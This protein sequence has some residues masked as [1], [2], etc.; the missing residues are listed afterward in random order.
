MALTFTDQNFAA[1]V[2]QSDKLSVVDFTAAWCGPCRALGN[3]INDLSDN[4]AGKVNIGKI[5]VDTNPEI[6]VKYGVTNLPT[7]LFIK[8]G[9]VVDKQV[10]AVPKSV[11]EK[12]IQANI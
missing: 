8:G 4:Y 7:V 6:S 1:E 3:I 12:K 5:D 11:L 10:G 2:L 9:S